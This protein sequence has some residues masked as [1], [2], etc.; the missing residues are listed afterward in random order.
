FTEAK[1][2]QEASHRK[3]NRAP[4]NFPYAEL[5]KTWRLNPQNHPVHFPRIAFRD[6]TNRT[7]T[8]TF[9]TSLIPPHVVTVQTAP[10]VMWLDPDHPKSDEAYLIGVMSSLPLDWWARR[11]IEGH[12]DQEAFNCLRI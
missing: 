6:V 5:S 8:R 11:F 1:V 4:R 2:I 7:N 10:W 9:V 3:W 12:A